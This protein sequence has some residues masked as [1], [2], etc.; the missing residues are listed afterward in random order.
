MSSKGRLHLWHF[1]GPDREDVTRLLLDN[2]YGALVHED[3]ASA[4]PEAGHGPARPAPRQVRILVGDVER[5]Y[6]LRHLFTENGWEV[7][8]RLTDE[9]GRPIPVV[10]AEGLLTFA[11]EEVWQAWAQY[12]DEREAAQSLHRSLPTFRKHLQ[13]LRKKR[14][15]TTSTWPWSGFNGGR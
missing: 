6:W 12:G 3:L 10:E 4:G 5:A 15:S 1:R 13:S 7:T 8:D 11:E 9:Q 2:R 14:G